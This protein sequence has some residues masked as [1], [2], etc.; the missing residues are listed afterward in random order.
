MVLD[1][2]KT[3]LGLE[4][5]CNEGDGLWNMNDVDLV[6]YAVSELEKI[7]IVSRSYLIDG[8][9]VREPNAYPFYSLNYQAHRYAIRNYISG[10]SNLQT[11]GRAGLFQ[12]GNSDY[13]LLTGIYAAKKFLG[14]N[15]FNSRKLDINMIDQGL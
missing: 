9:V 7:G 14:K 8:F 4:Y 1:P 11:I 5:F 6:N 15:D 10:F 12:Y 13:A 2:K 3:S